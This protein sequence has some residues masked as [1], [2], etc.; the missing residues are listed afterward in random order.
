MPAQ[1]SLGR[2]GQGVTA[3]VPL[4]SIRDTSAGGA[5]TS[6][7]T[8][9]AGHRVLPCFILPAQATVRDWVR[10]PPLRTKRPRP[11]KELIAI[12]MFRLLTS[13]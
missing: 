11:G 10:R 9:P 1:F 6:S 7:S 13:L 3:G 2:L 12:V 8:G 4:T 5:G